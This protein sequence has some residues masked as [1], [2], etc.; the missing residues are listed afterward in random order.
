MRRS[1]LS[2]LAYLLPTFPL[3]Y[4][5][6]L[7]TFHQQYASLELYRDEVIIPLGVASM[8]IQGCLFAWLY[9]RCFSTKRA[10]WMRSAL[11]FGL[12]FGTLGWSFLVLPVMAKYDMS[13]IRLFFLLETGFTILQY[14]VVSPLIALAWR[15]GR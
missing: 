6:H 8:V 11:S 10:D 1:L 9:P 7:V 4:V 12:I 15:E 13:S 5:W 2:F 14:A 3:G